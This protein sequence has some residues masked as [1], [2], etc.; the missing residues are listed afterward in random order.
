MFVLLYTTCTLYPEWNLFSYFGTLNLYQ[1]LLLCILVYFHMLLVK[2]TSNI[3]CA[4]FLS[5]CLLVRDLTFYFRFL[6]STFIYL[7]LIGFRYLCEMP[8][9][10]LRIITIF[11]F[12]GLDPYDVCHTLKY[13]VPSSQSIPLFLM[14][15]F[16]SFS[17]II[18]M[19]VT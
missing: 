2:L 14:Y 17:H 8:I 19:L 13:S 15:I 3:L 16:N 11:Y 10:Y 4:F 5:C 1:Y 6:N 18:L 7:L 12:L 9:F